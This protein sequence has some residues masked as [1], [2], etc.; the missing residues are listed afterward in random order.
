M[1]DVA[2]SVAV[3]T[4]ATGIVAASVPQAVGIISEGRRAR[5]NGASA[6]HATC[7]RRAWTS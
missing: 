6:K 7:G 5:P 1:T 2:L 3:I 4:A